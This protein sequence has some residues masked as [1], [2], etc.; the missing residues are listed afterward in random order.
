MPSVG[1]LEVTLIGGAFLCGCGGENV[2]QPGDPECCVGLQT[3]RLATRA[4]RNSRGHVG[5]W[6]NSLEVSTGDG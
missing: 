2:L 4:H 5:C 3:G 6:V 1:T